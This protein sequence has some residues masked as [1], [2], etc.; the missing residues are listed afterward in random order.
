MYT[1]YMVKVQ[2]A[3]KHFYFG[4]RYLLFVPVHTIATTSVAHTKR[5]SVIIS[6]IRS[7]SKYFYGNEY[8]L[9]HFVDVHLLSLHL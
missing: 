4:T 5:I 1:C 2:N 8:I 9:F 3:F 6:G 7:A